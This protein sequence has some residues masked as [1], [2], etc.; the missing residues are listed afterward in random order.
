MG[1]LI[2]SSR[3]ERLITAGTVL[4]VVIAIVA[5]VVLVTGGSDDG[6]SRGRDS[7]EQ[8]AYQKRAEQTCLGSKRALA[9]V[10][11]RASRSENDP[12][13]ALAL[14]AGA[15]AELA[16]DWRTQQDALDPPPGHEDA[17]SRL[18]F[19]LAKLEVVARG[20]AVQTDA[21]EDPRRLRAR[22]AHVGARVEQAVEANRLDRCA[23]GGLRIGQPESS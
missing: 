15:V 2:G 13:A 11:K 5:V 22:L 1:R 9:A 10:A 17:A 18:E 12:T 14:Y 23:K 6:D 19:A 8:P 20:V 3:R 21:G 16:G 4:A 7:G